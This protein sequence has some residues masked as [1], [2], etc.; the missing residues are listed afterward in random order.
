VTGQAMGIFD[1]IDP[2][3]ASRHYL[4]Q[5]TG[6]M[7][8]AL[9]RGLIPDMPVAAGWFRCFVC[10]REFEKGQSGEDAAAEYERRFGQA[11]ED[12]A[13]APFAICDD[14]NRIVS[15]DQGVPL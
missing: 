12:A 2:N 8:A 10:R 4:K 7:F 11:I 9:D 14:C 15:E 6:R 1:P 13:E 3:A 5:R